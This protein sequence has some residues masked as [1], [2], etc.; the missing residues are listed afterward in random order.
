VLLPHLGPSQHFGQDVLGPDIGIS[1]VLPHG[2][3]QLP[4]G[5]DR[6]GE[7]AHRL[8]R[9]AVSKVKRSCSKV[10]KARAHNPLK[11]S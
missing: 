3:Q 8:G 1:S 6:E 9:E 11:R 4:R 2:T 10:V 7:E 5:E